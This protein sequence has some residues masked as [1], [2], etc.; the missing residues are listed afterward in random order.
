MA[1]KLETDIGMMRDCDNPLHCVHLCLLMR[2]VTS[3]PN[4]L[5][6]SDSS[7]CADCVNA[8]IVAP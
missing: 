5:A 3:V 6:K 2:V 1:R 7:C 8:S 4:V